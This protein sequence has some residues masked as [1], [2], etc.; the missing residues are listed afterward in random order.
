MNLLQAFNDLNGPARKIIYMY[1]GGKNKRNELIE[2]VKE[3]ITFILNA[4]NDRKNPLAEF[5]SYI[6]SFISNDFLKYM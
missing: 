3:E 5:L 4:L 1:Y 6:L 2:S